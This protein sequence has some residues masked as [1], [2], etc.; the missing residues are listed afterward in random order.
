MIP[1]A[2]HHWDENSVFENQT[3]ATFPPH[4]IVDTQK[5]EIQFVQEWMEE[6]KLTCR[7]QGSCAKQDL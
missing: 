3:S 2:V 1:R 4:R 7:A 5:A 6:W